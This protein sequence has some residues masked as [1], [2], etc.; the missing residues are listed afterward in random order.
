MLSFY[1]ELP[2]TNLCIINA[3]CTLCCLDFWYVTAEGSVSTAQ[4]AADKDTLNPGIGIFGLGNYRWNFSIS[5]SDGVPFVTVY[6]KT[7]GEYFLW[8]RATSDDTGRSNNF[9]VNRGTNSFTQT[10]VHGNDSYAGLNYESLEKLH[11]EATDTSA[12]SL[13]RYTKLLLLG[14]EGIWNVNI[15][16]R[17]FVHIV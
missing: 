9:L 10:R 3:H 17:K 7:W 12:S 4:W 15:Y 8:K 2:A 13:F 1:E 16:Y 14:H 11:R 6:G 5:S